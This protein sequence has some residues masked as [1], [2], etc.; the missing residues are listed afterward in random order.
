MVA[1]GT[2]SN[3]SCCQAIAYQIDCLTE[4]FDLIL[5]MQSMRQTEMRFERIAA[6]AAGLVIVGL[7]VFLLVRNTPVAD[8]KLFFA[9]RVMLSLCAAV[10]GATIPGFLDLKWSAKA[11]S[12]RAGGALA[13]FVLTY[14]YT[15][16][17]E[18]DQAKGGNLNI[19]APGGVAAQ[20]ID[21]SPIT[22][23]GRP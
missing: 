17:L 12:I 20:T 14:T 23:G 19:A 3:V 15:P 4:S 5:I 6:T 21:H 8:P 7:V 9:L 11:M 10:L 1:G 22:V 2:T 16:V 13:L 18:N